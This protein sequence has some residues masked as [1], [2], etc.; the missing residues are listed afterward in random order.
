MP[1]RCH[2][3]PI[4]GHII[5]VIHGLVAPFLPIAREGVDFGGRVRAHRKA[6]IG[7][8]IHLRSVHPGRGYWEAR[9]VVR[10]D[11]RQQYK[12][13]QQRG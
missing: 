3:H 5:Q 11:R 9:V 2:I 7:D 8:R 1:M 13:A 4:R 6:H 12:A 10:V